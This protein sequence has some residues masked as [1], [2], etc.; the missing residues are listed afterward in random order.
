ML[1][2]DTVLEVE[3]V[4][5]VDRVLEVCSDVKTAAYAVR[6][7]TPPP[8]KSVLHSDS[9]D[10]LQYQV[11]LNTKYLYSKSSEQRTHWGQ[12]SCPL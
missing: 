2:V 11:C 3:R 10:P 12:T 8:K 7:S 9:S 1:A 6:K 5:E 4:L